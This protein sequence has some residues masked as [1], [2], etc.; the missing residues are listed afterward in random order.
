MKKRCLILFCIL[1]STLS[2]SAQYWQ[3]L[4]RNRLSFGLTFTG[5][6]A[7]GVMDAID[8]KYNRT[9]FPQ[10]DGDRFLG[11]EKDFFDPATSWKRKYKNWPD[12]PRPA[13]PG[14]KTWLVWSTDAWHFTKTIQLKSMQ[15]AVVTYRPPRQ[16]KKWWWVIADV[17]IHSLCFSAGFHLTQK[18]VIKQ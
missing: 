11:F 8:H 5:G 2:S 18:L 17:G 1:I 3:H 14:A 10:G 6:M 9:I 7:N 4:Q 13:Y 15:F 12:D 16:N